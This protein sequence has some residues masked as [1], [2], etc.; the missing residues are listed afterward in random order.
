MKPFFIAAAVLCAVPAFANHP[1][2]PDNAIAVDKRELKESLNELERLLDAVATENRPKQRAKAL[3]RAREELDALRRMANQA[4]RLDDRD[5]DRDRPMPLPQPV[6]PPPGTSRPAPQPDPVVYPMNGPSFEQ[7]KRDIRYQSHP[8]DQ[9]RVL[10]TAAPSN[11]FVTGQVAQVLALYSFPKDRLDA[12][13]MLTPRIL[14]GEN[15]YKL[16][17]AFEYPSDKAKLKELLER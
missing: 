2:L 15:A 6:P 4:P 12:A 11:W 16:Y 1:R 5:R 14:D 7:L 9:L 10:A 13:R 3:T 17:A 8:R